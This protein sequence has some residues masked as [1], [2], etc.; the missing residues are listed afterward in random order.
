MTDN[1]VS[2][3]WMSGAPQ[4]PEAVTV[5]LGTSRRLAAVVTEMGPFTTDFPRLL[6]VET[7]EDN[8]TWRTAW[9]GPTALMAMS[10]AMEHPRTIPLVFALDGV[11]AR[12]VRLRQMG[13]DPV[14]YWTIAELRVVARRD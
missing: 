10:A 11:S 12:Y 5:D 9:S 1:S 8:D 3:P 14:Y 2:T 6:V 13:T 7:S 4:R